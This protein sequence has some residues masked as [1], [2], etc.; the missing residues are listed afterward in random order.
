M[1]RNARALENAQLELASALFDLS[2]AGYRAKKGEVSEEELDVY[3]A[4]VRR[5]SEDLE[6]AKEYVN[7][8]K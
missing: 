5:A 1:F 3:R 2:E 8:L 4:R 7:S 6:L